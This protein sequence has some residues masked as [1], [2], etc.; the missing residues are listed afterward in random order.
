MNDF[1]IGFGFL[2][3]CV[4]ATFFMVPIYKRQQEATDVY[5]KSKHLPLIYKSW[6][7]IECSPTNDQLAP[8]EDCPYLG[9]GNQNG[10]ES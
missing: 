1:F 3:I 6:C 5:R 9:S 10:S 8:C 4:L 2:I 7:P